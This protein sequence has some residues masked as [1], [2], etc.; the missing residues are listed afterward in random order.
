M[1]LLEAAA[2]LS[3]LRRTP[4][5]TKRVI[6]AE[7]HDLRVLRAIQGIV[8]EQSA[9]PIVVGYEK[10]IRKRIA[11]ADVGLRAGHDLEV[12]EPND[13]FEFFDQWLA[14][15]SARQLKWSVPDLPLFIRDSRNTASAARLVVG[16][17]ADCLICGTSGEFPWHFVQL[18]EI[19]ASLQRQTA[20]TLHLLF[21]NE[22]LLCLS[23]I[24]VDGVANPAQLAEVAVAA[25]QHVSAIGA[26]P[27]IALCLDRCG[28]DILSQGD[29]LHKAAQ[30]VRAAATELDVDAPVALVDAMSAADGSG[31]AKR[32]DSPY[33]VLIFS[34][35]GIAATVRDVL[36][37]NSDWSEVGPFLLGTANRAHI[38]TPEISSK[39][40]IDM[41]AFAGRNLDGSTRPSD[42]QAQK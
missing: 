18:K 26:R 8:E 25:A 19:L 33:N 14:F 29:R 41:A 15:C 10:D 4:R 9:V 11:E 42:E 12:V 16:S 28:N 6:F 32:T 7:G 30:M 34:R 23:D 22:R 31:R 24:L 35:A 5:S 36:R 38:V 1:P 37:S 40:L 3:R 13:E 2:Q 21:A 17:R 39:T 20:G 27:R